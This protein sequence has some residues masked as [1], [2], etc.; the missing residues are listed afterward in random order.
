MPK[1]PRPAT[2]IRRLLEQARGD[3]AAARRRDPAARSSLEVALLYPGVHALWAYR[4]AHQLWNRGH[5]FS[6]RAL[7]QIARGA[8]GIEIHPAARIG[9]RFFIDHGMGVVI[10]E[11]AEVGDDVLMFHGVTLGGV[12][13]NP[14]KR[15]P[16]IGN[17]VQ[18]GAGAKVLGPVTVEDG[19]K[20]GANAVLVKNLPQG[21][22]AVGVPSRA[23]DPRTDPELM[24][25]PTIYI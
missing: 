10:G 11:T 12:S 3:L 6:A 20:I 14:G 8:T 1:P 22:V 18:I 21:H 23:R 2:P 17:N 5:H 16:T 4:A 7:A 19:A 13:M 15:H 24:L 25:D 9:E